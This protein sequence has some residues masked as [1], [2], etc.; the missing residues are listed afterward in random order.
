MFLITKNKL[1]TMKI[2]HLKKILSVILLI[3]LI[4]SCYALT[5]KEHEIIISLNTDGKANITENY[6]LEFAH[7][8]DEQIF[9]EKAKQN[10]SSLSAWRAEYDF[11]YTNLTN[12]TNPRIIK[13]TIQIDEKSNILVLNYELNEALASIIEVQPREEKWKINESVFQSF[14]E[15]GLIKIPKNTSIIFQIPFG[16]RIEKK[17]IEQLALIEENKITLNGITT[18]SIPLIYIIQK[19]IAPDVNTNIIEELFSNQMLLISL[20]ILILFLTGLFY[21][22]RQTIEKKIEN[23]I[24]E[25]SEIEGKEAEEFELDLTK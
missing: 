11:F 5:I 4:N 12:K 17:E 15:S 18:N 8:F 23:Y 7:S 20:I 22:K 6:Y 25:H 3:T 10:S 16:A 13:S 19:S 2:K 1:I 21:I 14:I 9:M 24:V